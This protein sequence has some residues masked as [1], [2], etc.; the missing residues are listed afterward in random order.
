[1]AEDK[2]GGCNIGGW[3]NPD[4]NKNDVN[5]NVTLNRNDRKFVRTKF[6]MTLPREPTIDGFWMMLPENWKHRWLEQ[7]PDL[8]KN[9]SSAHTRDSTFAQFFFQ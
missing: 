8:N 2:A 3:I 9:G 6:T 4:L 7:N 1:M 5:P